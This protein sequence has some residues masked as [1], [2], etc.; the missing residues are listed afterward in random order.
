[1]RPHNLNIVR[2]EIYNLKSQISN[3]VGLLALYGREKVAGITL[4]L[5][6]RLRRITTPEAKII[7]RSRRA[8]KRTNSTTSLQPL[9]PALQLSSKGHQ[10]ET[11]EAV[12]IASARTWERTSRK[13]KRKL[14][15]GILHQ[16]LQPFAASRAVPRANNKL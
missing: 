11:G 1:L 6:S 3:L 5:I 7:P 10:N 15:F 14:I 8:P 4:C 2:I 12:R 9:Y 16:S 13:Q